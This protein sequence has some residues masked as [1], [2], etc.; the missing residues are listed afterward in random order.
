MNSMS[1]VLTS[2]GRSC[3]V[4][5]PQPGSIWILRKPGTKV[6]H[7]G[8]QLVRA[9]EADHEVTITRDVERRHRHL[10]SRHRAG[11]FP[12]AIDVAVV[13]ERAAE[14]AAFE[15]LA[16]KVDIAFA[17]PGRAGFWARRVPAEIRRPSA[18]CRGSV[19][20][21]RR[22][23]AARAAATP[24]PDAPNS[25]LRMVARG[26]RPSS[27]SAATLLLEIELI[28][29]RILGARHQAGRRRL[30]ARPERHAKRCDRPEAVGPHES[31]LPGDAGAPIMP[32][33]DGGR[34]AQG[35]ENADHVADEM[36]DRVLVDRLRRVALAVA[37]HVGGDDTEAGGS[38]RVDLMPPGEP[39]FRKAMHQQHQRPLA[40]LGDVEVDAVAFDDP[41]RW[42]C[43]FFHLA[44]KLPRMRL[45]RARQRQRAM[46]AAPMP[47]PVAGVCS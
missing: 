2:F 12:V 34:R 11:D 10:Q 19:R 43:S 20:G 9:G 30:A 38:K 36:Q 33:D 8:K 44:P 39:G 35:I 3:W 29:L 7:V 16:V 22:L 40:L 6:L 4:Q 1:A 21:R 45:M 13:V 5:W 47:R 37:A 31:G 23:T 41:L 24:S 25:M 15:L 46:R 26:S 27:A 18:P 17:D 32:D 14:T 42:S 28:E